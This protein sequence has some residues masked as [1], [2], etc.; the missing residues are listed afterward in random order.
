MRPAALGLFSGLALA[1]A[2]LG[3]ITGELYLG[4]GGGLYVAPVTA[5][6]GLLLAWMLW[7][8]RPRADG[9]QSPAPAADREEV[10]RPPVKERQRGNSVKVTRSGRPDNTGGKGR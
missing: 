9:G 3:L 8:S 10:P 6:V 7:V 5:V 1:G 2:V 4:R